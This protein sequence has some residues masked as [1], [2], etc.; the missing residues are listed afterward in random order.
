MALLLVDQQVPVYLLAPQAVPGSQ[1][2]QLT[3]TAGV[4]AYHAEMLLPHR[5]DYYLLLFPKRGGGR[6]WVDMPPYDAQDA[7]FYFLAPGQLQVKEEAQPMWSTSLAFTPEFL[8]LQPHAAWSQLPLLQ[9]PQQGHELQLTVADIAFLEDVLGKLE[10]E[11]H[12]PA[13]E[14]RHRL[15]AAYLEVLLI[16]LSR[17][18][19]QQFPAAEDAADKL[20]LQQY[21]AKIDECF[22]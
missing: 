4:P 9:N 10:T 19:V 2:F 14:W 11:Y 12:G 6:H 17:L 16:Y 13:G 20:L 5:K 22:R 21:R 7:M 1:L 15:L 18:Y 8:A 3:R